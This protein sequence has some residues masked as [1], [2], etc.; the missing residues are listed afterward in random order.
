MSRLSKLISVSV[1]GVLSGMLIVGCGADRSGSMSGPQ[2]NSTEVALPT[3]A[4]AHVESFVL[5]DIAGQPRVTFAEFSN[6]TVFTARDSDGVRIESLRISRDAEGKI[7]VDRAV[8]Q[9]W[10]SRYGDQP[11]VEISIE[12]KKFRFYLRSKMYSDVNQCRSSKNWKPAVQS[13]QQKLPPVLVSVA[14]RRK[15][16]AEARRTKWYQPYEVLF[17]IDLHSSRLVGLTVDRGADVVLDDVAYLAVSPSNVIDGRA[18]ATLMGTTESYVQGLYC[19]SA[20]RQRTDRLEGRFDAESSAQVD[21]ELS[22]T[23]DFDIKRFGPPTSLYEFFNGRQI[24]QVNSIDPIR[25]NL[26]ETP[27][28]E[29]LENYYSKGIK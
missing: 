8:G 4:P 2:S 14:A 12:L 11:S 29:I 9:D 17:E 13:I 15:I 23:V 24:V 18:S 19:K 3:E 6:E 5:S 1:Y 25:S 21:V 28:E 22:W 10:T 20:R 27:T 26:R 16:Q 7:K